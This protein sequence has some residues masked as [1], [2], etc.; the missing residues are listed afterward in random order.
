[1]TMA[2]RKDREFQRREQEIITVAKNLFM[3]HGPDRVSVDLIVQQ[4]GIAKGTVYR[5]FQ[6]KDDIFAV[7]CI[8][9]LVELCDQLR[10]NNSQRPIASQIR[11]LGRTYLEYSLGDLDAYRLYRDLRHRIIPDKLDPGMRQR[12]ADQY[13]ELKRLILAVIEPGI[14]QEILPAADPDHLFLLGFGLLDGTLDT[15]LQ[16]PFDVQLRNPEAFMRMAQDVLTRAI[17]QI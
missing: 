6:S 7:I 3:T 9:Y 16:G 15:L 1:M 4:V 2:L 13:Q 12:L 8:N 14:A 17:T 10:K 5:H 11:F